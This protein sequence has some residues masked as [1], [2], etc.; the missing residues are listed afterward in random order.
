MTPPSDA[1]RDAVDTAFDI[2]ARLAE[3][4]PGANEITWAML[5]ELVAKHGEGALGAVWMIWGRSIA[6]GLAQENK[7]VTTLFRE[8]DGLPDLRYFRNAVTVARQD[9]PEGITA[10]VEAV[11]RDQQAQ[12]TGATIARTSALLAVGALRH[13]KPTSPSEYD[14]PTHHQ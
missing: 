13:G 14:P 9:D 1:T 11:F 8:Q 12:R 3:N 6:L 7:A 2:L 4:K 10:L 5:L